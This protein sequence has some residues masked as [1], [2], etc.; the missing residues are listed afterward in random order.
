MLPLQTFVLGLWD[1]AL[2]QAHLHPFFILIISRPWEYHRLFLLVY[3]MVFF[4]I[5]AVFIAAAI[6]EGHPSQDSFPI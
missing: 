3:Y 2:F 5:N 1:I 4:F 6:T